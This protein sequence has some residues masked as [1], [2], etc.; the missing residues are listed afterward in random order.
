MTIITI[1][2]P[3]NALQ[4]VIDA[5]CIQFE[6][7][8]TIKVDGIQQP[9]PETRAAFTRRMVIEQ[10]KIVVFHHEHNLAVRALDPS[11]GQVDIS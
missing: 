9:N 3:E 2:I 4:R 6:Y 10:I 8:P 5:Y 11:T 7:H 1:N